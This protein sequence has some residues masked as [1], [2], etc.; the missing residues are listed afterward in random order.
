MKKTT[1][2]ILYF[3]VLNIVACMAVIFLH[4]NGFVHKYSP[5][6]QFAWS[7]ALVVEVVA[8]FAV[9]IFL[10]LTGATL[11]EYRKRYDTRTFF[12][13]RL[14]RVLIPFILWSVITFA[15]ALWQ[16]RYMLDQLSF[17]GVWNIFMTS[18]MMSVYWFFPVI[19]SIY[20]A[21][22]ILSLLTGK[23]DRKWLWYM[24]SIGLITYS[25]L[26]PVLKLLGL[27]F[28]TSY[29]LPLTAGFV[30]FPIL[31]YLLATEK[32]KTKWLIAICVAAVG[33]LTLRYVV[34]YHLT[35]QNGSTNYL[36]ASYQYFTGLL[37]AA[38]VFL[39]AKRIPWGRYIKGKA[40]SVLSIVSSCSLGIYLIHIL[41]MN[42]ELQIFQLADSQWIWR[43]L[44]PF[45]TYLIC[46]VIV[47]LLKK[48]FVTR[49]LFP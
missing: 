27:S 35:L 11:M 2:R 49:N 12:K 29:A 22:P 47:L 26:P 4:H 33:A 8:F 32:I 19:I 18:D 7:Q 20:L 17:T 5:D 6:M 28:N 31:G 38:A 41:V 40:I 30:I 45:L 36:L 24:A 43:L 13:K 48:G 14:S 39:L 16:G 3:D 25:I 23:A 1:E 9:P 44:M 46:L 34:T 37:P 15:I 42:A 10:M 21:M